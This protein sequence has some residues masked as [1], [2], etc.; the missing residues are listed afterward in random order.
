VEPRCYRI[1]IRKRLSARLASAFEGVSVEY[2]G[3]ETSLVGVVDQS[4]LFGILD[5]VRDFGLE[6]ERVETVDGNQRAS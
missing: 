3:G 6:L 4:Q 1:T 5:R 2:G